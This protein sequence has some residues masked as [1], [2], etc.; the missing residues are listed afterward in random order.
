MKVQIEARLCGGRAFFTSDHPQAGGPEQ[1]RLTGPLMRAGDYPDKQFSISEAELDAAVAAFAQSGPVEMNYEHGQG[2]LQGHLGK[3]SRIWRDGQSL[4]A[5][6]DIPRWLAE[7]ARE[8]RVPLR[9]SPEWER[10]KKR[11]VAAAWTLTPRIQGNELVAAF[12]SGGATRPTTSTGRAA[13]PAGVTI[14]DEQLLA[15]LRASGVTEEQIALFSEADSTRA[16]EIERLRGERR[17][18]AATAWAD[19]EIA[20]HRAMPAQKEGMIALFSQLAADDEKAQGGVVVFTAGQQPISRVDALRAL[21]G[22]FTPDARFRELM[23]QQEGKANFSLTSPTTTRTG[24]T[25]VPPSPERRREL[26]AKTEEGRKVL[27]AEKARA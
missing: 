8:K 19:G 1:I 20:A 23:A 12:S 17:A 18:L 4:M 13:R 11:L 25:G 14:M 6:Y 16:A 24:E 26:L 9:V 21:F 7:L 2:P 3:I 5:S 27:E 15:R 10:E 22:G